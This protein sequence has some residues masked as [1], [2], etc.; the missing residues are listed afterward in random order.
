MNSSNPIESHLYPFN[1]PEYH[2]KPEP[3]PVMSTEVQNS[4]PIIFW[5]LVGVV[6]LLAGVLLY[7]TVPSIIAYIKRR[8][9]VDPEKK[10]R[11]YVTIESW[12][13]SKRVREHDASCQQIVGTCSCDKTS[14]EDIEGDDRVIENKLS[15][16]T[17]ET[18]EGSCLE[19]EGK[20]CP[21]CFEPFEVDQIV[22]WS[23][24]TLK[25]RHVF[26]HN[27]I[28]VSCKG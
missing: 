8:I 17:V 20:E 12:L 18:A 19:P 25:C 27:C 2:K 23:P 9:P 14:T 11:R 4:L 1:D 26:H 21:V 13:V 3:A 22:S 28:K 10:K 7:L 6:I 15:Y 16:D 24:N 5:V